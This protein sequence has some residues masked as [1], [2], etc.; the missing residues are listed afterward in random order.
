[1]HPNRAW[2]ATHGLILALALTSCPSILYGAPVYS[3][4]RVPAGIASADTAQVP[5]GPL[6]NGDMLLDG[7]R[8]YGSELGRGLWQADVGSDWISLTAM[9]ELSREGLASALL[10]KAGDLLCCNGLNAST[11]QSAAAL[12]RVS[13]DGFEPVSTVTAAGL[14]YAKL[15]SSRVLVAAVGS[16]LVAYDLSNPRSPSQRGSVVVCPGYGDQFG[17]NGVHSLETHGNYAYAF[18][19]DGYPGTQVQFSIKAVDFSDPANPRIVATLQDNR[20]RKSGSGRA[21]LWAG[22]HLYALAHDGTV[23]EIVVVSHSPASSQQIVGEAKAPQGH[24]LQHIFRASS[25]CL[26]VLENWRE[27]S[28]TREGVSLWDL[29]NPGQPTRAAVVVPNGPAGQ[30]SLFAAAVSDQRLFFVGAGDSQPICEVYDIS[31][32]VSPIALNVADQAWAAYDVALNGRYAYVAL[33]PQGLGIYDLSSS[34]RPRRLSLMALGDIRAV[35]A[36]GAWAAALDAG[37]TLYA[38]NCANPASPSSVSVLALQARQGGVAVLGGYAYVC[39]ASGPLRVVDLSG[40]RELTSVS[41]IKGTG[42]AAAWHRLAVGG[43][44]GVYL[45]DITNPAQPRQIARSAL[46]LLPVQVIGSR[47]LAMG[48]GADGSTYGLHFLD[49]DW[50]TGGDFQVT[51]LHSHALAG[52]LGDK[53]SVAYSPVTA[54]VEMW[55]WGVVPPWD[56]TSRPDHAARCRFGV[57]ARIATNGQ[58]TVTALQSG[59]I[60]VSAAAGAPRLA[61]RLSGRVTLGDRVPRSAAKVIASVG[62]EKIGEAG[63]DAAGNWSLTVPAF[64]RVHLKCDAGDYLALNVYP[65]SREGLFTQEYP[66]TRDVRV[67]WDDVGGINFEVKNHPRI[68]GYVREA[69]GSAVPNVRIAI[70]GW[71]YAGR[72]HPPQDQPKDL[73]ASVTTDGQGRYEA[74]IPVYGHTVRIEGSGGDWLFMRDDHRWYPPEGQA[75]EVSATENGAD[76]QCNIFATHPPVLYA[77]IHGPKA[78]DM[79]SAFLTIKY[80]ATELL[81]QP[82]TQSGQWVIPVRLYGIGIDIQVSTDEWTLADDSKAARRL[83]VPEDLAG[84]QEFWVVTDVRLSGRVYVPEGR[85]TEGI[86]IRIDTYGQPPA[87]VDVA[88]DRSWEATVRVDR[89]TV[90]VTPQSADGSF[91]FNPS[92]RRLTVEVDPIGGLGFYAVAQDANISGYVRG[93]D[94]PAAAT[95]TARTSYQTKSVHPDASGYWQTS[96]RTNGTPIDVW[97]TASGGATFLPARYEDLP[98]V[99]QTN[100]NFVCLPPPLPATPGV[101][102]AREFH[103]LGIGTYASATLGEAKFGP[104]SCSAAKVTAG[105]HGG[106]EVEL[107]V[108]WPG[109]GGQEKLLIKKTGLLG[110]GIGAGVGVEA[111]VTDGAIS[112][113]LGGSAEVGL[114]ITQFHDAIFQFPWPPQNQSDFDK[115][116]CCLVLIQAL[117]S[118]GAQLSGPAGLLVDAAM[119]AVANYAFPQAIDSTA[120]GAK[121]EGT[122]EGQ[123]GFGVEASAGPLSGS[124][125]VNALSASGS[126]AFSAESRLFKHPAQHNGASYAASAEAA[127]AFDYS[128][129]EASVSGDVAEIGEKLDEPPELTLGALIPETGHTG[130]ARITGGFDGGLRYVEVEYS[131][132][133][134]LPF[135]SASSPSNEQI[136]RVFADGTQIQTI[137]T[138]YRNLVHSSFAGLLGTRPTIGLPLDSPSRLVTNAATLLADYSRSRPGQDIAVI[139]RWRD[140]SESDHFKFGI[141][142]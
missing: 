118:Y 18:V 79:S 20:L 139:S 88:D 25:R 41:G 132:D 10:S 45:L 37:G 85:T 63:L 72:A 29:S 126:L 5:V 97:A 1:M 90:T 80:G 54:A 93:M 134:L 3:F 136:I 19:I 112:T 31:S 4:A 49:F 117:S 141:G 110:A 138:R 28:A 119:G 33:G 52:R 76:F 73:L 11:L 13:D 62:E 142:L 9:Y 92:S 99:D 83:D 6:T 130:R 67:E 71:R 43:P 105:I 120:V 39:N 64:A 98:S 89:A 121:I 104:L 32:L 23:S 34:H 58:A 81:R 17:F 2:A 116:A 82:A 36:D 51:G 66:G 75:I 128:V 100:I 91:R 95:V 8:L 12:Y 124:A 69:D 15:L 47:V 38:L 133:T 57:R 35:S 140:N 7:S 115:V 59:G 77:K 56:A 86:T 127:Y 42:L 101:A 108:E 68:S 87:T 94:N 106:S 137:V 27:N 111:E 53:K 61:V 131:A 21:L 114:N 129:M 50:P 16:R 55:S 40:Q 135:A 26:A 102:P 60:F 70:Y 113:T 96:I 103:S 14:G 74:E 46:S 107:A 24:A 30:Y 78:A 123:L 65:D 84:V 125:D 48:V 22:S 109:G 122:A 44:N